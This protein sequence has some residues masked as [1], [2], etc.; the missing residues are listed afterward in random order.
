MV[1]IQPHLPYSREKGL[2]IF[3]TGAE[4]Y[5]GEIMADD[6]GGGEPGAPECSP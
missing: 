1:Q 4:V 6:V 5:G 2:T 3:S